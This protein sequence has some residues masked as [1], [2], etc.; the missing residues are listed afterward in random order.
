VLLRDFRNFSGGP[1]V[2]AKTPQWRRAG[3]Q[4]SRSAMILEI[5][6]RLAEQF[7]PAAHYHSLQNH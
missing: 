6:C 2:A 3:N 7:E 5:P 1:D 4:V